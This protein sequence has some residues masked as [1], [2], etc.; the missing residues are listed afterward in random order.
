MAIYG[1]TA[2]VK[3]LLESQGT[4]EWSEP[5][6]ARITSLLATV[7][8]LIESDTGATFGEAQAETLAVE[9]VGA[10]PLLYLPKG[11]RSLT[12]VTQSPEWE[13]GAWTGGTL[14]TSSEYR[15]ASQTVDGLYRTV[16]RVGGGWWAGTVWLPLAGP[17]GDKILPYTTQTGIVLLW[18]AAIITLYTGYDYF[19]AGLKHVIE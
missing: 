7:S 19:R 4:N 9:T 11:L 13:N 17:A 12:S 8:A 15:L 10:G 1:S 14:L 16:L 6:L 3:G 2:G 18:V 5:E